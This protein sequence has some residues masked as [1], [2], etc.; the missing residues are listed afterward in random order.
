MTLLVVGI[1]TAAAQLA[2]AS[3]Q[4]FAAQLGLAQCSA[5]AFCPQ[6]GRFVACTV[7]AD[8]FRG[9]TC[10][11]ESRYAYGVRCSGWDL[12]GRWVV[13]QDYCIY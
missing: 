10:S 6:T 13:Y 7:Y 12:A 9:Q 4:E 3:E 1:L 11:Y 5:Q 8:N 2:F